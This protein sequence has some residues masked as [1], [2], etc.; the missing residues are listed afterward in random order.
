LCWL[1]LDGCTGYSETGDH[2]L[3]V[4]A[5]PDLALVRENVR[6]ACHS[7]NDKRN[8]TPVSDLDALRKNIPSAVARFF[9]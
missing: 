6:G 2:V 9:E 5:R 1:K 3:T 4:K 8:A 7:C